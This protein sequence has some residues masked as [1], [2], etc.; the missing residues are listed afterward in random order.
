MPNPSEARLLRD[1]PA[2]AI[3]EA[4]KRDGILEQQRVQNEQQRVQNEQKDIQIKQLRGQLDRG[5]GRGGAGASHTT[6]TRTAPSPR[7]PFLQGRE[8]RT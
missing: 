8:R 2:R 4:G 6:R 5:A 3:A 1:E 7:T